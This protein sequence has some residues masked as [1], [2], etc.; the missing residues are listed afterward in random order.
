[1]VSSVIT[2]GVILFFGS[3]GILPKGYASINSILTNDYFDLNRQNLVNNEVN[4]S[5][6]MNAAQYLIN[7]LDNGLIDKNWLK[8]NGFSPNILEDVEISQLTKSTQDIMD[9]L[10]NGD[11]D[12]QWIEDYLTNSNDAGTAGYGGGFVLIL[13]LFI[14]LVIIGAGFGG[15]VR[16]LENSHFLLVFSD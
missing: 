8:A 15:A 16:E 14:L 10:Q 3:S 13:V 9:G 5:E 11:V 12:Q 1:M 7:G 2:L 4:G 6:V